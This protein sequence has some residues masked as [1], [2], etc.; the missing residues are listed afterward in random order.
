[1]N[2]MKE[3]QFDELFDRYL[4]KEVSAEEEQELMGLLDDVADEF[5]PEGMEQRL[6]SFI[7]DLDDDEAPETILKPEK[8]KGLSMIS[9]FRHY[10]AAACVALILGIGFTVSQ[11]GQKNSFTDT[12]SSPVEAETQML[13]ALTMLNSHSQQGLDEARQRIENPVKQ[14]DYSRFISFE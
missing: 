5:M 9:Y 11:I 1:M 13:R 7:E 3:Q 10:A 6:E 4:N 2:K 14:T 12:C 8:G